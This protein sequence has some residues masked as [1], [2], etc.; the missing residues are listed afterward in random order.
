MSLLWGITAAVLIVG[1]SLDGY[2]TNRF[3]KISDYVEA[4]PIMVKIFGTSRPSTF[5]IVVK[6]GFVILCELLLAG[7]A[8]HINHI[9]GTVVCIAELVQASIHVYEFFRNMRIKRGQ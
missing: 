3:I 2:S 6:G 1:A 5:D 4:D 9:F 7:L 8:L